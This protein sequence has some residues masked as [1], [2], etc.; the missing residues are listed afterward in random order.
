[1]R[2]YRSTA[3]SRSWWRGCLL[4]VVDDNGHEV[5][6]HVVPTMHCNVIT[7]CQR[8]PGGRHAAI[9]RD[10]ITRGGGVAGF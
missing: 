2:M 1:M 8:H 3:N 5:G 10:I 4:R 7:Y 9:V 6:R